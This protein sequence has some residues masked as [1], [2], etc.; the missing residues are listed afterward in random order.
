MLNGIL[1]LLPDSAKYFYAV[2]DRSAKEFARGAKFTKWVAKLARKNKT[3]EQLM[4]EAVGDTISQPYR[5][6]RVKKAA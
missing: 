6:V 1:S 3:A 2:E 5:K 4:A